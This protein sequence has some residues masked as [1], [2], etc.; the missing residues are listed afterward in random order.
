MTPEEPMRFV[1]MDPYASG[2]SVHASG[3][4]VVRIGYDG[5]ITIA[6][7][8]AVDD[9]AKAFWDAIMRM[10]PYQKAIEQERE[11]SAKIAQN[12]MYT[13]V[14]CKYVCNCRAEIANKIRG[15]E[16]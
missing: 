12:H 16:E 11:R 4:E 14:G 5:K 10:N 8:F 13:D 1:E 9:A 6:E 7:G 2:F 15:N 3:K